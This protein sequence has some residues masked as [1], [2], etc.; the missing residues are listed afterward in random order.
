MVPHQRINRQTRVMI[1]KLGLGRVRLGLGRSNTLKQFIKQQY[2]K[3]DKHPKK[4]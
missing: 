1:A 3:I 4:M 2:K